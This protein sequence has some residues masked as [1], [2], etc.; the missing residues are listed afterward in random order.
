MEYNPGVEPFPFC[1]SSAV[2][3]RA[4]PRW[5]IRRCFICGTWGLCK[6]R[7]RD[8]DFPELARR[9]IRLWERVPCFICGYAGLCEHR[10]PEADAAILESY[11]WLIVPAVAPNRNPSAAG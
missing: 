7:E 4:I 3:V 9:L 8:L 1:D 10:E 11:R 5:V 6:H 2:P